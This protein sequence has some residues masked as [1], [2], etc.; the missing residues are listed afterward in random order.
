MFNVYASTYEF[1][2]Y[3]VAF[4]T[5]F[6]LLGQILSHFIAVSFLGYIHSSSEQVS[7]EHFE[8]YCAIMLKVYFCTVGYMY[9]II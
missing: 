9:S 6:L 2:V 5:V 3:F 8:N 7:E 4:I 1:H